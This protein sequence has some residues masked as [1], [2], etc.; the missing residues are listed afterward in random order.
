MKDLLSTAEVMLD[1]SVSSR[2]D[3]LERLSGEAAARAGPS[4]EEI[5]QALEAREQLGSTA[6][7]D[8]VAIPHA[9]LAGLERP[10]FL[11]ARLRKPIYFDP[12]DDEPVDLVFVVLWPASDPKGLLPAMG[13]ICGRVRDSRLLRRLRL[14]SRGDEIVQLLARARVPGTSGSDEEK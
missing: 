7:R 4:R 10:L 1:V 3:L 6:L 9:Q 8:G 12:S 2:Q 13:G 5:L 11:F 14:A